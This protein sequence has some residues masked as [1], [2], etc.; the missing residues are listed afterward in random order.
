M[1][2]IALGNST[3]DIAN[4][5]RKMTGAQFE[6]ISGY[7]GTADIALAMER[8]EI[9]GMCGWNW[10]SMKSQKPAWIR[11]RRL[12]WLAQ[13][14]LRPNPDLT[15]L[16]APEFWPYIKTKENRKVAEVVV[17]QQVFE[18]PYFTAQGTPADRVALLR[19]AFDATMRDP[20]FLADAE[21]MNLDVSPLPGAEV[22]SMVQKLYATPPAILEQAKQA[23]R[24]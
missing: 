12:N 22:E 10:S 19:A 3:N 16:G 17:S 20:Q 13:I 2:G 4:M 23:I 5:V 9:E 6:L 8:G 24:P 21:K 18:R 11:E 7:T 1:G 14:G 15:K